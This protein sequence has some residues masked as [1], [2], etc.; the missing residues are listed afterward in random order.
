MSGLQ[1]CGLTPA[2]PATPATRCERRFGVSSVVLYIS[3]LFGYGYAVLL[4]LCREIAPG[5]ALLML[6]V[7]QPCGLLA[8]L[9]AWLIPH[10]DPGLVRHLPDNVARP[11]EC[12]VCHILRPADRA[13]HCRQCGACVVGF[14][15]HCGV[16]GCCI[17]QGNHRSFIV[18]LWA[19]ATA[20]GAILHATVVCMVNEVG[21]SSDTDSK[22]LAMLTPWLAGPLGMLVA[23]LVFGTAFATA[24]PWL[25]V[26][27][28]PMLLLLAN[29]TP[30]LVG[31]AAVQLY[32]FSFGL[33]SVAFCRG[34][35]PATASGR[36]C[37]L[38]FAFL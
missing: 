7:A 14:D 35:A 29:V 22:A 31:F 27:Y 33:S 21:H 26:K 20:S 34:D 13:H 5:A 30:M 12:A 10:I 15:H 4:P 18:L 19:G 1:L 38:C 8:L 25:V 6:G 3:L 11:V 28:A 2:D 23:P 16:L 17:A 32:C 37:S 36:C 24:N 9:L